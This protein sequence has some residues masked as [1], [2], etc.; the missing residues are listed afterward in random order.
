LTGTYP[1]PTLVGGP[2]SNYLTSSAAASTYLT[3][4]TAASTY[5]T[6]ATAGTTYAPLVSPGLT[7]NPTAPTAA[8]AD[9]D[10]SIATTA[11]TQTARGS[12]VQNVQ[13][14]NYTLVAGDLG[15]QIYRGSGGAATWT[16][17]ANASV[18]FG[19]GSELVFVND[20]STATSIAITTDVLALSPGGTAGT[21]TLATNGMALARKVTATRWLISGSGLT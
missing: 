20:S 8:I 11:F 21:R 9:N 3:T 12:R 19:I 13:T 15:K 7:G 5:L 14:G 1:N 16:I 18:A 10:T 17:P 6:T 2:L 4:A